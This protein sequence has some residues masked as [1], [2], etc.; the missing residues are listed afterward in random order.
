MLTQSKIRIAIFASGSGTNAEALIH[1]SLHSDAAFTVACLISNRR[2]AGALK[3]A[4]L[5]NIP[6]E[7]CNP[8]DFPTEEAYVAALQQLLERHQVQMILLAGYLK[9]IPAAI[10]QR[11][12]GRIFN[13]HPAL[14]PRFGGKGM[15]G[16]HVHRAVLEAH[17]EET[18]ITIHEVTEEY[19]AG[20]ILLQKRIPVAPSTTPEDLEARIKAL[21]HQIYPEFAQQMA[22]QLQRQ[23][24]NLQES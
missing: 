13:I 10:I 7:Y 16:R 21:E 20:P 15:Y 8:A 3:R 14:L 2:S 11:Y 9:K 4:A 12:R 19:D 17:E 5:F 18:G 6:A 24:N 23:A 1:R 22:Q